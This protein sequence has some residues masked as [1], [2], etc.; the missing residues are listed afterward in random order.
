MF[1]QTVT[2]CVSKLE[3]A[4]LDN[5]SVGQYVIVRT[6]SAGVWCGVLKQKAGKEVILGN[7]RRMWHWWC[8][9][10]ISLSGVV[11]HGISQDKSKIA[12]PVDAVWMEAIEILPIEGAPLQSILSAPH[13][14]AE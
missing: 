6:Y 12:P 9:K 2:P 10:S 11:A 4:S 8:A 1:P 7:A 5:F 3:S 13:A 14:E